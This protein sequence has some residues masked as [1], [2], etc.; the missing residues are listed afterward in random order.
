[1]RQGWADLE[2]D[3]KENERL[4][5]D[6]MWKDQISRK[7]HLLS[8]INEKCFDLIRRKIV[9]VSEWWDSF[10][11]RWDC[12]LLC[13]VSIEW[14]LTCRCVDSLEIVRLRRKGKHRQK[15]ETMRRIHWR[16]TNRVFE[17]GFEEF[18]GCWII[19]RLGFR[20]VRQFQVSFHDASIQS[21][22]PNVFSWL[23]LPNTLRTYRP[24]MGSTLCLICH[25]NGPRSLL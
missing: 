7:L 25:N 21:Q 6:K 22:L 18:E 5:D 8:F 1:M 24:T 10:V 4:E 3:V 13:S 19:L 11:W 17:G 12:P 20:N 14:S 9:I 15:G 23:P 2:M 16:R